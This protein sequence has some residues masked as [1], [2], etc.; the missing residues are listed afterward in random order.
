[1]DMID[2]FEKDS[3]AKDCSFL[4]EILNFQ[5]MNESYISL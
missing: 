5:Y 1:M 4:D 2:Y 3:M